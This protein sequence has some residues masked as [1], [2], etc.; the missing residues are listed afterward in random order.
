LLT[1]TRIS[2][3]RF[4]VPIDVVLHMQ[5]RN[6]CETVCIGKDNNMLTSKK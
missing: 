3:W 4:V 6:V 1:I 2:D 5:L